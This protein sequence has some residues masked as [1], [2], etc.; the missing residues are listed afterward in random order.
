MPTP[1]NG[2]G[3]G[4][5]PETVRERRSSCPILGTRYLRGRLQAAGGTARA[6][7]FYS[8]DGAVTPCV[9]MPYSPVNI[10]DV[11]AQ[12]KNLND[13]WQDPFFQAIRQWQYDYVDDGRSMLSPC[14]NRDHHD[15]LEELLLR[16]QPEPTDANA[17][18]TLVDPEYTRGLVA[19]SREFDARTEEVWRSTTWNAGR[20][21]TSC[22][23]L[24]RR[25]RSTR[26][27]GCLRD[28]RRPLQWRWPRDVCP[29]LRPRS[30]P[31]PAPADVRGW[32]TL[33]SRRLLPSPWSPRAPSPGRPA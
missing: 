9:F 8:T 2:L 31:A 20:A 3:C 16:F 15:E 33:R 19:Y 7:Y 23:R 17:A 1:D 4:G 18:E 29:D 27:W 14:P 13:V 28:P 26:T 6:A 22:S 12:G 32:L 10:R 24:C 25:C 21:R 11:Y 5:A 30:L